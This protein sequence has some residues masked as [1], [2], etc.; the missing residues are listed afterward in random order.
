MCLLWSLTNSQR[1]SSKCQRCPPLKLIQKLFAVLCTA[2]ITSNLKKKNFFYLQ[3]WDLSFDEL[4]LPETPSYPSCSLPVSGTH[5][6]GEDAYPGTP[7]N[8]DQKGGQLGQDLVKLRLISERLEIV[9]MLTF[10]RCII[11]ED[12]PN[13]TCRYV[14]KNMDVPL[15]LPN[16]WLFLCLMFLP[17]R[18]F[19][20]TV[21][22][23]PMR[24]EREV[25]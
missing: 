18:L 15:A 16:L 14:V 19:R 11:G 9:E 20:C 6:D 22:W 5:G 10:I 13:Q 25:M 17:H 3:K 23:R 8:R 2:E 24:R 4:C 1:M 21:I 7:G 12:D